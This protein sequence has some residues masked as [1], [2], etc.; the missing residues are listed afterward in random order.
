[1]NLNCIS[2]VV[3]QILKP[4]IVQRYGVRWFPP[5]SLQLQ[6]FFLKGLLNCP[7]Y[8]KFIHR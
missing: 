6:R 2:I 7:T 4:D 8:L 5:V 3:F 1:M